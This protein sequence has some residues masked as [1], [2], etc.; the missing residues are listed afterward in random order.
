MTT[1]VLCSVPCLI[2]WGLGVG[3]V[4]AQTARAL[5]P[6]S[7][8]AEYD[9][10]L[11]ALAPDD[12]NGHYALADWCR[13][14]R[15]Y[16][17]VVRE[18]QTVLRLKPGHTNARLLL[19]VAQQQLN[20]AG[21]TDRSRQTAPARG[22]GRQG[23]YVSEDDIQRLRYAELNPDRP[24]RVQVRFHNRVTAEFVDLMV[25][26]G[27]FNRRGRTAFLRS[28][29]AEKLFIMLQQDPEAYRD[30][31]EIRSDPIVFAQF[32][33]RILPTIMTGCATAMCHGGVRAPVFRLHGRKTRTE[34]L[35]YTNFLI[36]HSLTA[37]LEPEVRGR[38]LINRDRPEESLLLDYLLPRAMAR[39][40][41]PTDIDPIVR[42]KRDAKYLMVL[43]WISRLD[44]RPNYDLDW[45]PPGQEPAPAINGRD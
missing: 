43:Q 31:I 21:P 20:R 24:E 29:P 39:H 10:R 19:D 9:T 23:D 41:H 18:C 25:Q 27:K 30:D 38:P 44:P 28:K 1:R 40:P 16:D 8:Q 4:H 36:L 37:Q 22:P 13:A 35:V 7:I 2:A 17:L 26:Q 34:R 32:R 42:S 14:K 11:A 3:G 12:I 6:T 5:A 45:R 15:R 33:K